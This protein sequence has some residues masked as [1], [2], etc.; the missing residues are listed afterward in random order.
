MTPRYREGRAITQHAHRVAYRIHYGAFDDAAFV[1]HRC[2]NPAC[3]NPQHLWLGTPKDNVNDAVKKGR[4]RSQ[5]LKLPEEEKRVIMYAKS[6]GINNK[7]LAMIFA[8]TIQTIRLIGHQQVFHSPKEG[9]QDYAAEYV[10]M[11]I[12][13]RLAALREQ[14]LEV[15]QQLK[16]Q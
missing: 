8:V 15:C 1:C 13:K 5:V 16:E 2:D 3:V 9:F 10:K 4:H 6:R 14:L 12:E 7:H 11:A